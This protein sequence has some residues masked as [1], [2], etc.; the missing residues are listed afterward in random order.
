MA[1]R[2]IEQI[3]GRHMMRDV[4]EGHFGIDFENNSL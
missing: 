3:E 1:K 4:H 2:S